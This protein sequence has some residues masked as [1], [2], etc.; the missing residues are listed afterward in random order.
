MG[1]SREDSFLLY[2]E[3]SHIQV[4]YAELDFLN[5]LV[6]V[7][8]SAMSTSL[9]VYNRLR[10]PRRGVNAWVYSFFNLSARWEWM[11]NATHRPFYPPERPFTYCTGGCVC[12]MAGLDGG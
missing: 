10:R 11:V 6:D 12:P 4:L 7:H 3:F 5:H 2:T 9:L 1:G 8:S